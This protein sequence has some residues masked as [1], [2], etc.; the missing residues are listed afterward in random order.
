MIGFHS[1]LSQVG[2]VTWFNFIYTIVSSLDQM[3]NKMFHVLHFF[4]IKSKVI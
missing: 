4:L 2:N 3:L 1:I